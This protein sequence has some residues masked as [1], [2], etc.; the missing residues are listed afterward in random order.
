M[1]I[2]NATV[3]M[4]VILMGLIIIGFAS[5]NAASCEEDRPRGRENTTT[6]VGLGGR[7]GPHHCADRIE[8]EYSFQRWSIYTTPVPPCQSNLSLVEFVAWIAIVPGF[9]LRRL[10][11]LGYSQRDATGAGK[12]NALLQSASET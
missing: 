9:S 11:W 5:S 12:K 3:E 2:S 4:V 8:S 7:I 10:I 6:S 1:A